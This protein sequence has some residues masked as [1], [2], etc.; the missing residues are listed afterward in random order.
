MIGLR[1]L[2]AVAGVL[3]VLVTIAS[4]LQTLVVPRGLRSSIA[5]T[6]LKSVRLTFIWMSRRWKGYESR[7]RVLAPAMPVAIL[8]LMGVWLYML[9]AGYSLLLAGVGDVT[10][11]Q[12][13]REAGS[14]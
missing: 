3:L 11:W 10:L 13:F 6:V 4:M 9:L 14:S 8:V 7:D 5:T 1:V 2:A 12:G